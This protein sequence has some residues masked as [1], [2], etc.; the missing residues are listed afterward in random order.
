MPFRFNERPNSR[1]TGLN[2][3]S[4]ETQYIAAGEQDANIVRAYANS[5]TPFIATV[6]GNILF[7]NDIVLQEQGLGIFYATISY[8]STDEG[9]GGKV[10]VGQVR[11]SFATT[12]GTFH[13][14]HSRATV[15]KYP[16]SAPDYE[17]AI[18]VVKRDKDF[19]IEGTDI[20]IPA[21]K[22]TYAVTHPLGVINESHARALAGVTGCVNSVQ[23][24]GFA[25]GEVIFLGADGEDGTNSEATINYHVACESNLAGLVYG[26][27]TGVTKAGH[28]LLWVEK[29]L[30][31]VGGK[32][33]VKVLAVRV[34]QV[35][36][37]VNLAA[38]LGF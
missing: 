35:Y 30:D 8:G 23:W 17:Q 12:G 32:P 22:M 1:R 29:K 38:V 20:I 13:I 26:S 25:A 33:V 27:I 6:E 16:G 34:E 4:Y 28:D 36:R 11:F 14:T 21:L 24:R 10:P 15:A 5:A 9:N 7:R 18:N 19:D 2:P 3:P 37:R 31:V